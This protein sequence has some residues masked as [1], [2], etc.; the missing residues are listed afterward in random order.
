MLL[1]KLHCLIDVGT[2]RV[3]IASS[4]LVCGISGRGSRHGL[5]V[6]FGWW[7]GWSGWMCFARKKCLARA[8]GEEKKAV[9]VVVVVGETTQDNCP[10]DTIYKGKSG[11]RW[12]KRGGQGRS[13]VGD[14]VS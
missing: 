2:S 3:V 6:A 14:W 4:V 13:E 12:R 11:G 8:A 1:S 10:Q 5:Y 9:L 7:S